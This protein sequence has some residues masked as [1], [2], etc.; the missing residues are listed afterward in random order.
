[1]PLPVQTDRIKCVAAEAR[2]IATG[3]EDGAILVR[4]ERNGSR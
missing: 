3:G 2:W 4:Y 1:V